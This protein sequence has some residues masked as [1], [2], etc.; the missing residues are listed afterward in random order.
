[1]MSGRAALALLATAFLACTGLVDSTSLTGDDAGTGDVGGGDGGGGGGGGDGGGGGADAGRPDGGAPDAGGGGGSSLIPSDR[2][3]RWN[4]GILSDG[5]L[6]LPLG[7][8]GLPQRV[9]ICTTV[10]PGGDIQAAIDACPDNQVVMLTPGTF[11]ISS[12]IQVRSKVVLRGSGSGSTGGTTIVKS[13]GGTVLAIGTDRDQV[14]YGNGVQSVALTADAPKDSTSITVGSAASSFHAGDLIVVDQVDTS[15]V[16]I[17]DCQYYKRG[18]GSTAR[19][20]AQVVQVTSVNTSA[21]TLGLG[22]ALHWSYKAGSPTFAQAFRL[23]S[24]TV[25]WAGIESLRIQGGTMGAYDG[26]SAGGIDISNAAFCWVKDVQTDQ[27]IGGMHVRLG[28]TYRSVVRDGN[29]HHSANY[30]YAEDCYGVVLGCFSADNLVEN[31]IVRYMNK[32]VLMVVSGGGNVIGYNYVDNSWAEGDWQEINI[33]SHC[34]F[35][36]M[37]L[38]EGNLA[39]HMGAANTHGN[40][41]YFTFFRN[42]SSTQFASPEIATDSTPRKSNVT[43]LEL[44]GGDVGMNVVGNVLGKVGVTQVFDQYSGSTPPSI[45][46]LGQGSPGSGQ[47]DIVTTSLL[48]NGNW[49]AFHQSTQWGTG[50][51]QTLPQ[52]LYLTGK[53]AWWPGNTAWPWA[54]P[55]LNPM[56]GT[57]PAKARSDSL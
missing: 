32:P 54:G 10:A 19:S 13:N 35:S 21:G 15:P 46:E 40:A 50:G 24:T 8:D 18:S 39:P 7:T 42:Y 43:A 36:H 52:S 44:Q 45:Y 48:R 12:T 4:P 27:T 55:D 20:I 1:M 23:D 9:T 33:D 16:V 49:D 51:A 25:T 28:A 30:G 53:P 29:F 11:T 22:A 5:P 2:T 57:L 47:S 34:S 37:E 26:Q 31:N 14:C 56:V 41:G 3:T 38:I 17:G 6:G